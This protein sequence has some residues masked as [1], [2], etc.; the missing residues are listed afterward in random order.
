MAHPIVSDPQVLRPGSPQWRARQEGMAYVGNQVRMDFGPEGFRFGDFLDILNP[1]HKV[2]GVAGL[3]QSATGDTIKPASQVAGL[4]L[5]GGP[6][7]MAVAGVVGMVMQMFE[8]AP[9]LAEAAQQPGGPRPG[10]AE[11]RAAHGDGLT[12]VV[13]EETVVAET[14]VPERQAPAVMDLLS[15]TV[16][17]GGVAVRTDAAGAV[18]PADS[19]SAMPVTRPQPVPETLSQAAFGAMPD[20]LPTGPEGRVTFSPAGTGVPAAALGAVA[21]VSETGESDALLRRRMA[22]AAARYGAG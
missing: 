16:A 15:V 19:P 17:S 22:A 2:P 14:V 1:A 13:A 9:S 6:M 18:V 21:E 7:T 3:Y 4:A 8:G 11:A 10:T 12:T 20:T 5:Y